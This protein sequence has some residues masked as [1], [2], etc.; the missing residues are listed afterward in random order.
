MRKILHSGFPLSNVF[1]EVF[2]SMRSI[3]FY[4]FSYS[5][6][7]PCD[8]EPFPNNF[9]PFPCSFEP[10]PHKFEPLNFAGIPASKPIP[11]KAE[12]RYKPV[13]MGYPSHGGKS[14]TCIP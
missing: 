4:L 8:F 7:S 5:L 12:H 3:S 2:I 13:G 10:F 11:P 1:Y 14:Q 9:E 6:E